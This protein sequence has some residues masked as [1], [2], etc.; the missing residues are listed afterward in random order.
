MSYLKIG[1]H[2]INFELVGES[3]NEVIVFVNGLTQSTVF[4]TAYQEQLV[5]LGYRVLS[6]DMLGQGLSSKPVLNIPLE[7]HADNLCRLLDELQIERCIVAGISF[8]GLVALQMA[9]R[10]PDR[11]NGLVPISTFCEMPAQLEMIGYALHA[12]IT[13][14]GMPLL[15]SWLLPFNFSS[16]WIEHMRPNLKETVRR[17]YAINDPYAIQNLMES[18][19]DFKPFTD[20]LYKITC[21]TLIL[22]GEFDCLTPRPCHETLRKHIQDSR[23]MIIPRACHA[24]TIEKSDLSIRIIEAFAQSIAA[25]KWEGDQ[26]V[27]V[28]NDDPASER[29]ASRCVGDHLRAIF[30][31]ADVP[32]KKVRKQDEWHVPLAVAPAKPTAKTPR[33]KAAR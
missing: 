19:I 20:Q 8:G 12:S 2:Q 5:P 33:K 15:Q 22:N 25:G 16:E 18:F 29:L 3:G 1:P 30:V 17:S 27:W 14:A 13:Q 9:M 32:D 31:A 23:L 4:W 6:Y 7:V 26:T 24:F 28:A 11:L 10:Y 21:P